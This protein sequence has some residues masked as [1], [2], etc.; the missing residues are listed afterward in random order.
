MVESGIV[1]FWLRDQLPETQICPLNLGSKERQLRNSDLSLTYMI[2]GTGYAIAASIFLMEGAMGHFRKKKQ[3]SRFV[4]KED[5]DIVK[6]QKLGHTQP[7]PYDTLFNV[8]KRQKKRINGRDYWV[9]ESKAGELNLVPMRT[10]SAL[11][12]H[13]TN[14]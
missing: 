11:L 7:P 6:A 4:G 10:P 1:K 14:Y 8:E 3:D 12:F 2:V 9:V 5:Q 13:Y